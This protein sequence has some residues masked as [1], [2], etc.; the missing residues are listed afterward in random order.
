MPKTPIRSKGVYALAGSG[1]GRAAW[2]LGS[3]PSADDF[4]L[5]EIPRDALTLALNGAVRALPKPTHW[6]FGDPKFARWGAVKLGKVFCGSSIILNRKHALWVTERPQRFSSLERLYL[7][8]NEPND[9]RRL[10]NS[11]GYWLREPYLQDDFLPGRWTVATIAL[12]LACL[13]GVRRAILVGVDLG[14]PGGRYYSSAVGGLPPK[15][16]DTYFGEW[17][18]WIRHGFKSGT[19]PLE[20]LSTSPYLRGN[21]PGTPI[22]QVSIDEAIA[23]G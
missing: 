13:L 10:H 15:K 2:I 6:L 8:T 5:E 20:V 14:A 1:A 18:K 3:G 21:C 17:R 9:A 7:F 12:S 4:P 22:R 16:Q 23:L 11:T 19:W